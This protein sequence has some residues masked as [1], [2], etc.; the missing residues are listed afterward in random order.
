MDYIAQFRVKYF[1]ISGPMLNIYL[2]DFTKSLSLSL[3]LSLQCGSYHFGHVTCNCLILIINI[4]PHI[5]P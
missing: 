5:L 3:S 4:S 2:F 1:V